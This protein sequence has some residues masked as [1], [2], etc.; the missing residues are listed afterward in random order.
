MASSK[1]ERIFENVELL[2]LILMSIQGI[3]QFV[4]WLWNGPGLGFV[5]GNDAKQMSLLTRALIVHEAVSGVHHTKIV[6]GENVSGLQTDLDCKFHRQG[7]HEVKRLNLLWRQWRQETWSWS[8]GS[9]RDSHPRTTHHDTPIAEVHDRA[10]VVPL[11]FRRAVSCGI[12]V[13][14]VR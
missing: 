10:L 8:C 13:L 11:L 14:S 3:L 12:S 1:H 9:P 5:F 6:E 4:Q 7:L 2:V